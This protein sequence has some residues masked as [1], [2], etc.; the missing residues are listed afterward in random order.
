[1]SES[2]V[3]INVVAVLVKPPLGLR[4][5]FIAVE[6]KSFNNKDRIVEIMD[7]VGRYVKAEKS[8]PEKWTEELTRRV[9]NFNGVVKWIYA[10][11]KERQDNQQWIDGI[12]KLCRTGK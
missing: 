4:P 5:E 2:K 12:L 11:K 1:M 10:A 8:I 6:Q 7:A 3:S 9:A